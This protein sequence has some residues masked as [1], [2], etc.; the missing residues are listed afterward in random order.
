MTQ[1]EGSRFGIIPQINNLEMLY[2]GCSHG[3]SGGNLVSG[4]SDFSRNFDGTQSAFKGAGGFTTTPSGNTP[5]LTNVE[6]YRWNRI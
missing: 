4:R 2:L 5:A 6:D 1:A 3:H